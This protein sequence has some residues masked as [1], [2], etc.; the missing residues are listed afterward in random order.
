MSDL[1]LSTRT[2]ATRECDA[3]GDGVVDRADISLIS[4]ARGQSS[5]PA[6]SVLDAN[7]DGLV[8]VNDARYCVLRCDSP[9]C[10]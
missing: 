4:A 9:R 1:L 6:A 7:G 10:R 2:V 3:N 5:P 8:T